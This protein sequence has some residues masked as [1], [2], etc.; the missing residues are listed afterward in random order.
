LKDDA[1]PCG[2]AGR[3]I[4]R[5][6]KGLQGKEMSPALFVVGGE[7]QEGGSTPS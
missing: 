3:N 7:N 5:A 2:F 1:S 4:E 6:T